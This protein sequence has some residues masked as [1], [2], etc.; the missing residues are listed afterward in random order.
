MKVKARR[1]KTNYLTLKS[2]VGFT[3][4]VRVVGGYSGVLHVFMSLILA[5]SDIYFHSGLRQIR[6]YSFI[7]FTISNR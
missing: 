5:K 6:K 4:E 1:N 3:E 7:L 2:A